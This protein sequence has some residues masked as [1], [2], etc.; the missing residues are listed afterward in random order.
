M[1][2][3]CLQRHCLLGPFSIFCHL[4]IPWASHVS[5]LFPEGDRGTFYGTFS[6]NKGGWYALVTL[7]HFSDVS[8]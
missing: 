3:E 8:A 2:P 5:L 1:E 6:S 4:G 7:T